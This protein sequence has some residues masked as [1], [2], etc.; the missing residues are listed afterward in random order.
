V[1][2]LVTFDLYNTLCH[3][4][5]PRHERAAIVCRELGIDCRPDDFVRPNVLAEELYTVE[6]GRHAIHARTR[7]QQ[8][9]FYR[10][11]WALML[12]EAGLPSEDALVA[13]VYEEMGRRR[14]EWLASED[15]ASTLAELRR[16][17][18]A[19]GVISNTPVDA[20]ELCDR[21]GIC[22]AVDFIV[23]SCLVGCEKPC[24]A[25]FEAALA[26]ADVAPAEAVHVG[27]QP[28]SDA[29]GARNVGMHAL[30]LDPHG[31][32]A[33]EC[34]YERVASLTEVIERVDRL[35]LDGTPIRH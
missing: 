11:M 15:A 18:L 19:V 25:I 7:D 34:D 23:S 13:R 22:G 21:I 30:L 16:R 28:R 35:Q 29:L 4:T 17:G 26:L 33:H 14:G 32:L 2:R 24:A 27:D 20:T 31:L 8:I 9:A 10:Q 12:R 1:I 6:N 5:P 3:A